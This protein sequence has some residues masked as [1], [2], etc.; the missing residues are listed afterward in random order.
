MIARGNT[1]F[2]A[3]PIPSFESEIVSIFV[4]YIQRGEVIVEKTIEDVDVGDL[5]DDQDYIFYRLSQEDTLKFKE[6]KVPSRDVV[7][8]QVRIKTADGEAYNSI[9]MNERVQKLLKEGVI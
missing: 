9:V 5:L 1:G 6:T 2:Y 8:V 4:T 3:I 7:E